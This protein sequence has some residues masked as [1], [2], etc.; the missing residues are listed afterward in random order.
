M[1]Q[2]NKFFFLGGIVDNVKCDFKREN[3]KTLLTF[4]DMLDHE[5]ADK[6]RIEIR[7]ITNIDNSSRL[8]YKSHSIAYSLETSTSCLQQ[9]ESLPILNSADVFGAVVAIV[10]DVFSR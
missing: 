6:L 10:N 7:T 2:A 8:I 9:G 5:N 4:C 1:E 3:D